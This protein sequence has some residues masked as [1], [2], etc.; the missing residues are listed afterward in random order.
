MAGN[1]I[2]SVT[3]LANPC[4]FTALGSVSEFGTVRVLKEDITHREVERNSEAK[5]HRHSD[6]PFQRKG[7]Q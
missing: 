1:Q 2:K 7:I 6:E 5:D 4:R 3:I